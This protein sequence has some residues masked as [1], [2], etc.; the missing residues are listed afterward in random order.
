MDTTN[1]KGDDIK[2]YDKMVCALIGMS[3]YNFAL[4]KIDIDLK[5]RVILPTKPAIKDPPVI[6]IKD[7]LYHLNYAIFGA[8]NTFSIIIVANLIDWQVE[9]LVSML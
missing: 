2:V 5:N 8:N 4:E 1:F 3:S 9:A 6:E 7:I